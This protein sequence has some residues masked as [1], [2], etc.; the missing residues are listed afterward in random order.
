MAHI[1]SRITPRELNLDHASS[2]RD[3]TT[4]FARG[5]ASPTATPPP[6]PTRYSGVSVG[7]FIRIGVIIAAV[8]VGAWWFECG[9]F[10]MAV[11]K[12][13]SGKAMSPDQEVFNMVCFLA[14]GREVPS[15]SWEG[16]AEILRQYDQE[17]M[18]ADTRELMGAMLSLCGELNAID[19]RIAQRQKAGDREARAVW[20]NY[21][22]GGGA[23]GAINGAQI[24]KQGAVIVG[25]IGALKGAAQADRLT[26]PIK[27]ATDND[28]A[29]MKRQMSV[30]LQEFGQRLDEY[31]AG[32]T[33]KAFDR[34]R[35]FDEQYFVLGAA[36]AADQ[37][38][39]DAAF[40]CKVPELCIAIDL[41]SKHRNAKVCYSR[42]IV[43]WPQSRIVDSKLIGIAYSVLAC[44]AYNAGKYKMS[45]AMADKGLEFDSNN[46]TLRMIREKAKSK[47]GQQKNALNGSDR[48]GH[49][50]E[51]GLLDSLSLEILAL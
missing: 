20:A 1:S 13:R 16:A 43:E 15:K 37:E 26:A 24:G 5:A 12:V 4:P 35:L 3:A 25:A 38:K 28:I 51:Q 30:L 19:E 11:P 33:F 39:L 2:A 27:E 36:S 29:E 45:I 34:Q 14:A 9:R 47:L 46:G 18:T 21:V 40:R 50:F 22:L 44:D 41:Y 23:E 32:P 8:L 48:G 31:R 49:D 17:M 7:R 42:C 10:I 6:R